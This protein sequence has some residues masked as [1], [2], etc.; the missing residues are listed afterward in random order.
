VNR[1]LSPVP[2]RIALLFLLLAIAPAQAALT[3]GITVADK[4]GGGDFPLVYDRA[5]A[6]IH[7]DGNDFKVVH[8]AASCLASDVAAVTGVTPAISP[9][10]TAPS[11]N[12]VLIG[13]IGHSTSIDQ[14][15]HAGKLDVTGIAGKWESY[16]IATVTDPLPGVRS[17]LVIAGSDRRGT[18]YGV[19]ELSEA[20][21]VSP[22]VWWADVAPA[23]ATRWSSAR[24]R[25]RRAPFGEVPWN[26]HQ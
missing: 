7:V 24:A 23:I 19:F 10:L 9:G 3:P 18:A 5:S 25:I 17:A 1:A 15:I 20:I 8:I 14:L 4:L 2:G 13:T 6:G 16:I 12:L 11:K 21:G 22:W 26:F